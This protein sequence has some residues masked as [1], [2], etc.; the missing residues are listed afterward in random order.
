MFA[1]VW[2]K[3]LD[4]IN[5][6]RISDINF[7]IDKDLNVKDGN[8]SFLNLLQKTDFDLNI[9]YILEDSDAKNLKF[10]L[11][12]FDDKAPQH[13]FI[14]NIRP[15]ENYISCIFT[16]S[17][18]DENFKVVIEEL[19]YS[20]SLLDKALLE[21]REFTALLQNF[22]AYYFTYDGKKIILKNT[23]DMT[24]LA[25]GTLENFKNFFPQHFKLNFT[26][27]DSR[28]QF[29]LMIDDIE[30]FV[31]NKYYSFLQSNKK[32]LTVHTLKT[33]TRNSALI[34]GNIQL[35][36][37][38]EVQANLYNGQKDGLTSLYNKKAITELAIKKINEDKSPC[39]LIIIDIDKFKECNDTYGHI[40]GDRVLVAVAT[41]IQDAVKGSGMAGRIGGDEFLVILDRTSEDD[42]R[43]VARNIRT[44][45]LWNITNVEPGS[46]VT[47]SMGIAK[48][49][50][51]AK[52]YNDLFVLADKCLYIAKYRGRNCYIIYKPEIHDKILFE[53]KQID[54][55]VASGQYFHE[56]V[57][58]E[59]TILDSIEKIKKDK[60]RTVEKVLK[61]II[62][63]LK[64]SKITVYDENFEAA[65]IVSKN[66]DDNKEVRSS[67][68]N[69]NYFS[70]FN[71][72]GF[73]H[74]DNTN[75]LGSI[76]GKLYNL[77]NE[78]NIASTI[79]VL[80]RGK[81]GKIK[82]FICYDLYRPARAF[83]N[84]T[85][86]LAIVLANLI[87]RKI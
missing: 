72:F 70:Y 86:T 23:K 79:E 22:D 54:D 3:K 77:Y 20:R 65:Y 42:I 57:V 56:N 24:I 33:S 27:D 58:S 80:S 50:E 14:A 67:Q 76:D 29:D 12:N 18:Y 38:T 36:H 6:R 28:T 21:S 2:E 87:T 83:K 68:L 34:V 11:E 74:F 55:R 8:R 13:N 71:E 39:S 43:N 19:S 4:P 73:L 45:I 17:R 85:V 31:S 84:E 53:N 9:S 16:I 41:C 32:R 69:S 1:K 78:N 51:Q 47:C 82:S 49:P 35:S 40:F 10:Y 46:I 30:K 81:D 15:H 59:L 63:Y 61:E 52:N 48:F 64:I 66:K 25:S 37:K 62:D 5:K 44:A 7:I 26:H 60:P 75:V